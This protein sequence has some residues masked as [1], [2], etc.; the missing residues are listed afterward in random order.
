MTSTEFNSDEHQ[1]SVPRAML[2]GGLLKCPACG[3]GKLFG[4]YLKAANTCGN[5]SE[6][7]FH[8]RADDAPPYF[9]MILVGHL[10]FPGIFIAERFY[11]PP[12]W[13][14]FALWAPLLILLCLLFL[15][16]VK[17]TIIGLQWSL[18]MHGFNPADRNGTDS[19][20][21]DH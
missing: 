2:R 3:K 18:F 9:T 4:R 1:R 19:I 17:G 16:V 20:H 21:G 5:C 14:H 10:V 6:E 13:L 11:Q 15:P 8:H 12:L 7:L